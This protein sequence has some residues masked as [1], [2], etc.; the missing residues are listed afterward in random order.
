MATERDDEPELPA[1]FADPRYRAALALSN[2]LLLV[3]IAFFALEGTVQL[4]VYGLAVLDVPVTMYVLGRV[5][6]QSGP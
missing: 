4:L 1:V 2:G 5:A 3:G 6:D